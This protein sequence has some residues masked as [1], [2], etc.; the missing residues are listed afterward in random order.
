[1]RKATVHARKK[2]NF[3]Q[4]ANTAAAGSAHKRIAE[5]RV[6]LYKSQRGR[7][8]KWLYQTTNV[9]VWLD[10]LQVWRLWAMG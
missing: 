9:G 7:I 6:K 1:M 2:H 10:T 5:R 3:L 8:Q 4:Q